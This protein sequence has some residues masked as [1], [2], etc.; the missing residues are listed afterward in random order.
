MKCHVSET[1]KNSLRLFCRV[2]QRV[3][4][5][6]R[7]YY[8]VSLPLNFNLAFPLKMRPVVNLHPRYTRVL[9]ISPSVKSSSRKGQR[10]ELLVT[11]GH[12]PSEAVLPQARVLATKPHSPGPKACFI[13]NQTYRLRVHLF[14]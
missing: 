12:Q 8:S 11:K 2:A 1:P 5:C 14:L 9:H 6:F 13:L 10:T 4:W 3:L 7:K